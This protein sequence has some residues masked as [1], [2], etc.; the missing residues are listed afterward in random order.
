MIVGNLTNLGVNNKAVKVKSQHV[1]RP[2]IVLHEVTKEA[3]MEMNIEELVA[4]MQDYEEEVLLAE[5][6]LTISTVQTLITLYQ[7]AIEYYSALDD[8]SY[9]DVRN[10]MQ[11]L[12]TRP[13]VEALMASA[14]DEQ[15]REEKSKN[16]STPKKEDAKL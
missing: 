2:K 14:Q 13:D 10:R 5:S 6:S 7:K 16:T 11:S 15:N 9:L 8:N 1:D 3:I 4:N 12:L